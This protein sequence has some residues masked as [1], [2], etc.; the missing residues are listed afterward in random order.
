MSNETVVNCSMC[1]CDYPYYDFHISIDPK[2]TVV[3]TD[4]FHGME[5]DMELQSIYAKSKRKEFRL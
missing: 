5:Y 2:H 1:G 4:C 3:C